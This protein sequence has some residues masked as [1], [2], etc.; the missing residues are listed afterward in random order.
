[1]LSALEV[2]R[3]E[4]T[5]TIQALQKKLEK[6]STENSENQVALEETKKK[7]EDARKALAERPVV[8]P[9]EEQQ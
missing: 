6:E 3:E 1:M 8:A 5:K 2:E 7:L 9:Q 4:N